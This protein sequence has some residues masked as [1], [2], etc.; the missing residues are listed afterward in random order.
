MSIKDDEI[1]QMAYQKHIQEIAYMLHGY[2]IRHNISI[3]DAVDLIF[4]QRDLGSTP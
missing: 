4:H 3:Q 2:A 1:E